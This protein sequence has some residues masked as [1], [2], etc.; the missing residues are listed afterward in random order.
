MSS[1]LW[2]VLNGRA[3]RDRLQHRGLYFQKAGRVEE[4][5]QVARDPRA[6]L[7]HPPARRAH[8]QVDVA[9]PV[10]QFRVR[11]AM[12]L[13]GERPQRLREQPQRLHPHRELAGPGPEQGP[14][15]A[16]D[17]AD[18]PAAERL[19]GL[20]ERRLLQ[21]QLDRAA[22]I[23]DARE[24][25]LAHHPLRHHPAGDPHLDIQRL[26]RRRV[27]RRIGVGE[28]LR[29][30]IALEVVRERLAPLAQCGELRATLG[31]QVVLGRSGRACAR[32]LAAGIVFAHNPCFRLACKNT[33][34]SPSSTAVVLPIS[35]PVRRSLIRDWSST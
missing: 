25:R 28:V 4:V 30:R 15:R 21:E 20:A 19:V 5:A 29:E 8:D 16:D 18:V 24:A 31:D 17:V 34:R 7:E 23:L 33:S 27:A 13:V 14:A 26:E 22:L 10:A 9:L 12:P 6:R 35:T 32:R 2:C 3:A 11:D 1:A